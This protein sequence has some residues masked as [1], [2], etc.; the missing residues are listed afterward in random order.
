MTTRRRTHKDAGAAQAL[1]WAGLRR[2]PH[3][4]KPLSDHEAVCKRCHRLYERGPDEDVEWC[5]TCR[6]RVRT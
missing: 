1:R 4:R 3:V 5:P 2:K 6:A